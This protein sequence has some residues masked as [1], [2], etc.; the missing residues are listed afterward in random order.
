MCSNVMI[1]IYIYYTY[2][3]TEAS[4]VS[5][6]FRYIWNDDLFSSCF[7]IGRLHHRQEKSVANPTSEMYQQPWVYFTNI[8]GGAKIGGSQKW[9]VYM[10]NPSRMDDFGVPQSWKPPYCTGVLQN[11]NRL[12]AIRAIIQPRN[13]WVPIMSPQFL[14]EVGIELSQRSNPG[15]FTTRPF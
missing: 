13:C 11:H 15:G 7:P 8:W 9:M 5:M 1:Y 14:V 12:R 3:M 2:N 4:L 10:E 6:I